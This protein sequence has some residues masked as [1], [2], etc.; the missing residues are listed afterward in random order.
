[1]TKLLSIQADSKTIKG[2]DYG[3]MTAILYLEPDSVLCPHASL[4]CMESCLKSSGRMVMARE[5]RLRR[6]M[7]WK[8]QRDVF[9]AMLTMEIEAFVKKANRK[10]KT[11]TVRL[12]G[13][14]DIVW[15][16][17]RL[18]DGKT[19]FE[20]FPE[21]QFYDYTPNAYRL[22][23][24]LPQNYAL[25]FSLK[26]DNFDKAQK[27]AEAGHNVAVVFRK[28]L[29][30]TFWGREVIDGDKHDL[31]FLD[32]KGVIVGLK[33]KGKARKDQ[34]G[35]VVDVEEEAAAVAA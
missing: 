18:H 24:D 10:G 15:E 2:D 29:P 35:F 13:T 22:G 4:G 6:T 11:P 33:A 14:S 1:M 7:L 12:N 30:K 34:S 5:A 21:V 23:R 28:D 26:E 3:F 19:I 17:V 31:R 20:R 32:P 16:A 8:T 9:L 25:T 27:M